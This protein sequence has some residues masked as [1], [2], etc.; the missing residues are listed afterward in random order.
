MPLGV[1]FAS[2]SM[3]ATLESPREGELAESVDINVPLDDI[4]ATCAARVRQHTHTNGQQSR[5]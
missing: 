3:F 4:V 2:L 5:L 1:F